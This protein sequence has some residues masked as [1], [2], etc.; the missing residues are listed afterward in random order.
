[1]KNEITLLFIGDVVGKPGMG[2]LQEF[3]PKYIQQFEPDLVVINGENA[4]DGKGITEE[5]SEQMFVLGADIITSGNH[6]WDNWKGKALLAKNNKILRPLNYPQGNPG[7]GFNYVQIE[8]SPDV[9]VLNLQGRT[10]M[11]MIDCPFK[12]A[13]YALNSILE[14]TKIVIVDFHAEASAEKIAMGWHLN[15][16]V[17]AVLG[18]HTHIQTNDAT[19]LNKG[20]AFISDVGMTGPYNSVV[21]MRKDVALKRFLFQTPY[22]FEMGE[23]DVRICGVVVKIETTTGHATSIEPFM[24]PEPVRKR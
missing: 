14:K 13:D 11:Q 7:F 18:T 1:V 21:G 3:M 8:D 12:S 20:T 10:Y 6:V 16:R 9:A 22:K 2:A 15:G 4:C 17:S 24:F 19:I 23:G 5:E